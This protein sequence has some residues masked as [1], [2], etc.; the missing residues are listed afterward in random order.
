MGMDLLN[1]A[2]RLERRFGARII[3]AVARSPRPY[4]SAFDAPAVV[5]KNGRTFA[6][7]HPR[8]NQDDGPSLGGISV[9]S[10]PPLTTWSALPLTERSQNEYD[11]RLSPDSP[12]IV[13]R[14]NGWPPEYLDPA[15]RPTRIVPGTGQPVL[16]SGGYGTDRRVSRAHF[17]LLGASP[18]I[19]FVNGVPRR[20]GGIRPP[21]RGTWLVEPEGRVLSPGEEYLIES[22]TA[23]VVRLPNGTELRIDA[24]I[25]RGYSQSGRERR[26]SSTP[27]AR[28]WTVVS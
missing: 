22:G 13:G 4:D 23:M 17:M 10:G 5:K 15:Y 9:L 11:L 27:S 6:S 25:A 18:G 12:V 20:G 19:L 28:S 24:C 8:N 1:L 14:S 2:F 7:Q 3:R 21:L 26:C 16:H